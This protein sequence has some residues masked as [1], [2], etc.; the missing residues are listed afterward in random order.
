MP[1]V[2]LSSNDGKAKFGALFGT[3]LCALFGR[4]EEAFCNLD[5]VLDGFTRFLIILV[6]VI[7]RVSD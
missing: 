7:N 2:S 6:A 5:G 1:T 3:L 4:A